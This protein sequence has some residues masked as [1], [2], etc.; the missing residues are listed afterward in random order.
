MPVTI[1]EVIPPVVIV[2]VM[3]KGSELGP[4]T[5]VEVNVEPS[6]VSEPR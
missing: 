2:P 4:M 1:G 3:G 5:K 6:T